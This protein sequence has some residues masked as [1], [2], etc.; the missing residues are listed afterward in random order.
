[1]IILNYNNYYYLFD[2]ELL[3]KMKFNDYIR[4][5][6]YNIVNYYYINILLYMEYCPK[7]DNIMDIGRSIL[8]VIHDIAP[9][10]L[11]MTDT[12]NTDKLVV[13]DVRNNETI[14]RVINMLKNNIDISNETVNWTDLMNHVEFTSI[15]EKDKKEYIKVVKGID[16]NSLNAFLICKN[17]TYS[18]KIT[19][20]MIVLNNMSSS[21]N[22]NF[23]DFSKYKYM[24]YDN[25]LPHTRDYICK[26][27]TCKSHTNMEL[28]DAKW[29]RPNRGSYVTYYICCICETIWNIA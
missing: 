23:D 2:D 24:K 26:N 6:K 21:S 12:S 5:I 14:V 17:C 28:K 9:T 11:S 18:E 25:T 10:S 1:M 7:C 13:Q 15:K 4:V 20:R 8:K 3:K 16:D 29:F 22:S 27:K 19:K